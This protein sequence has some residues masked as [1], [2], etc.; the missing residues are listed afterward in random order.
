[1]IIDNAIDNPDELVA[2]AKTI[3]F[4]SSKDV[5]CKNIN[6]YEDHEFN[7]KYVSGKWRGFRS[8]PLWLEYPELNNKIL[9]QLFNKMFV[10]DQVTIRWDIASHLHYFPVGLPDGD[11]WWHADGGCFWAGVLYLN[12]KPKK[13]SGTRIIMPDGTETILDNV[14][15]RFVVYNSKLLHRPQAGFGTN[16]NNSRLTLTLF[17]YSLEF[18]SIEN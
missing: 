16:T 15:N 5:Q 18:K 17:F 14:Y 12:K 8:N 13:D 6:L 4:H 10:H 1:M 3:K 9:M 11:F 2:L 7:E